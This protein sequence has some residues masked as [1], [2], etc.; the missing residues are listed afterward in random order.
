MPRGGV[1]TDQGRK[2]FDEVA[3]ADAQL[4]E[5]AVGDHDGHDPAG[6]GA[7]VGVRA[8]QC[9]QAFHLVFQGGHFEEPFVAGRGGFG[10]GGRLRQ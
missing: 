2:S 3:A 7:G 4:L 8:G 6:V 5:P 9:G 10:R 1:E